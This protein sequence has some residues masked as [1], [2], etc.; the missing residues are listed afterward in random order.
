MT[1]IHDGTTADLLEYGQLVSNT[2]TLSSGIG[3]YNAY[4]SGS[5]V[6]VDIIPNVALASTYTVNTVKF[7][8]QILLRLVFQLIQ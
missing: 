8:L 6:N 4:L 3:T 1:V 2:G 5:N 7:L